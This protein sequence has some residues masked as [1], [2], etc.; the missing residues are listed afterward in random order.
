VAGLHHYL[1]LGPFPSPGD[2]TTLNLGFYRRSSP[3]R[4]TVGAS[5]RLILDLGSW[6]RS[7]GVLPSGQSGHPGS[8]HYQ[9]QT[10]RWRT[11]QLIDFYFA[12]NETGTTHCLNLKP[13]RS[14][15]S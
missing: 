13:Y 8:P 10:D 7:C 15:E 9:D 1:S 5:L 2:G 12:G 6:D 3:Y 14:A 11:G 4:H